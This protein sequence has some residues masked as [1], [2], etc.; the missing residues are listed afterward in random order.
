MMEPW[1]FW[2][3]LTV[4]AVVFCLALSVV[5]DQIVVY[6]SWRKLRADARRRNHHAFP[7]RRKTDKPRFG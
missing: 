4:L 7:V 2:L 5:I 6:W 3:A 1:L